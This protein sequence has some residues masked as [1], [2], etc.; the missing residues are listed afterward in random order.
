MA[1]VA[2]PEEVNHSD[3]R[4]WRGVSGLSEESCKC[5]VMICIDSL[6][7][8]CL[9]VAI[10]CS[11]MV[12]IVIA[13]LSSRSFLSLLLVTSIVSRGCWCWF[14]VVLVYDLLCDKL[15]QGMVVTEGALVRHL[16]NEIRD[17][18]SWVWA[19]C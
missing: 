17:V 3:P 18:E 14:V 7:R 11:V 15:G 19:C 10:P 12:A 1:D 8:Q 4:A 16:S 2:V 13:I 6:I 9:L 5:E